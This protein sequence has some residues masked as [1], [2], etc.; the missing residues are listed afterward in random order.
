M[1]ADVSFFTEVHQPTA[2]AIDERAERRTLRRLYPHFIESSIHQPP[3]I[4]ADEQRNSPAKQPD[5]PLGLEA[6]HVTPVGCS[7]LSGLS[8]RNTPLDLLNALFQVRQILFR[9]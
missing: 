3:P 4:H 1:G 5:C 7:G 9:H 2:I 6:I 8:L